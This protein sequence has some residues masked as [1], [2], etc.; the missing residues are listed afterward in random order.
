MQSCILLFLLIVVLSTTQGLLEVSWRCLPCVNQWRRYYCSFCSCF[1]MLILF[2]ITV[3]FKDV[4]LPT[5]QGLCEE[6][7][8]VVLQTFFKQPNCYPLST[9]LLP[10]AVELHQCMDEGSH[11]LL[12]SVLL[13][14]S[15]P[16][17]TNGCWYINFVEEFRSK[18]QLWAILCGC[19]TILSSMHPLWLIGISSVISFWSYV[20]ITSK[21]LHDYEHFCFE[22]LSCNIMFIQLC[23]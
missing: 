9:T 19:I 22:L 6:Q 13:H 12:K 21:R 20:L 8:E 3:P 1:F 18:E 17:Y 5:V 23:V 10:S 2:K 14:S 11:L 4:C 16:L 15:M 7:L